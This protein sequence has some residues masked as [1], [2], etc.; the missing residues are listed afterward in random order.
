METSYDQYTELVGT[1][2]STKKLRPGCYYY[3]EDISRKK[4]ELRTVYHGKYLR[5]ENKINVFEDVK[6]IVNP[7][8]ETGKPLGFSNKFKY[9]PDNS[10]QC[11]EDISNKNETV[12]EVKTVINELKVR[13]VEKGVSQISF[14][15]K[16]Y[17]KTRNSFYGKTKK[18]SSGGKKLKRTKRNKNLR[19]NK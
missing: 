14:I 18:T 16:T 1:T 7:S 8:Q 9:M 17:R 15:G 11:D 3:I 13:P 4:L 12:K 6:I 5:T 10:M 19:Y 2:H